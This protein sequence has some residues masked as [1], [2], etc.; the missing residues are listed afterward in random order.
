MDKVEFEREG[1]RLIDIAQQEGVTLRLA[2]SVAFALRCPEHS[3]LQERLGRDYAD[4]DLAGVGKEAERTRRL[5]AQQGYAED[6]G[7]YVESQGS[8]L[9]FLHPGTRLHVDVFLDRMEFCHTVNFIDRLR[10]DD[11]TLPLAELLLTKMQIVE[12]NEKDLID[13]IILLLEHPLGDI[14]AQTINMDLIA[15][16]CATD[17]G[18][19]RTLTMNLEKVRGMARSYPQLTDTEKQRLSDQVD[20]ALERVERE[21]KSFGWRVRAKVGDRRKWYTDVGELTPIEEA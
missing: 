3:Y 18:W 5:F 19:W 16:I 10:V 15:R 20:R 14:D 17:W 11:L 12:I 1:V 9:V 7:V 13:T 21:P 2:G 6:A 8:R 4:V